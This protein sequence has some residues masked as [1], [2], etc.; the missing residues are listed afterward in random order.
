MAMVWGDYSRDTGH[1]NNC[2]H[3]AYLMLIKHYWGNQ[4]PIPDDDAV[5]WRAACCDS[6]KAWLKLR[7]TIEKFFQIEGGVWRHKRVELD[8]DNAAQRYARR[9]LGATKTNAKRDAQR[10]AQRPDERALTVSPSSSP[11]EAKA[12]GAQAPPIVIRPPDPPDPPV[13]LDPARTLFTEGLAYLR[14]VG[15]SEPNARQL[16]GKWRKLVGD[17]RA[18]ELLHRANAEAVSEPVAW[19]EAALKTLPGAARDRPRR[20]VGP[21]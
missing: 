13:A 7:P 1:L 11:S 17:G 16:L 19:I 9:A 8:L 20:E 12:S 18:I 15:V 4:R 6:L 10:T 3:G 2:L 14:S 21:F 5:L